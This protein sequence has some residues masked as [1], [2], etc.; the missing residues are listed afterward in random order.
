MGNSE[1][2]GRDFYL[3]LGVSKDASFDEIKSEYRWL[4]RKFHPDLNPDDERAARKFREI[5]EAYEVLSNA[6]TRAEYDQSWQVRTSKPGSGPRTS[7]PTKPPYRSQTPPPKKPSPKRTASSENNQSSNSKY[8]NQP[9]PGDPHKFESNTNSRPSS[10]TGDPEPYGR[11]ILVWLAV[12]GVGAVLAVLL[13]SWV[14]YQDSTAGLSSTNSTARPGSSPNGMTTEQFCNYAYDLDRTLG[15]SA[16][17]VFYKNQL[18]RA[19]DAPNQ[20]SATVVRNAES[21][22]SSLARVSIAWNQDSENN[23]EAVWQAMTRDDNRLA[24]SCGFTLTD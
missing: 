21:L 3:V 5:T 13:S 12:V 11:G 18:A 16:D 22:V 19:L 4:A 2:E 10:A 23:F 15:T 6:E 14:S 1:W 17:V 24:A 20:I 9:P 7:Q 8:R